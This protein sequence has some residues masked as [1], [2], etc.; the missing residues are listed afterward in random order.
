MSRFAL[1]LNQ[2]NSFNTL[3]PVPTAAIF[4]GATR[5]KGST[6]RKFNFCKAHSPTPSLCIN[7]FINIQGSNLAPPVPPV[8]PVTSSWSTV[9]GAGFAQQ[10]PPYP[11]LP[12]YS[13]VVDNSGNIYVSNINQISIYSKASQQWQVGTQISSTSGTTT[14]YLFYNNGVIYIGGNFTLLTSSNGLYLPSNYFASY[15]TTNTF[16]TDLNQYNDI[17]TPITAFTVKNNIIYIATQYVP[18]KGGPLLKTYNISTGLF[19]NILSSM[20]PLSI[21]DVINNIAVDGSNNIFISGIFDDFDNNVN[22]VLTIN[23]GEDQ[24]ETVAGYFNDII[25]TLTIDTNNNLYIGGKF[26]SYNRGFGR[27]ISMNYVSRLNSINTTS[28]FPL[29]SS[30]GDLLGEVNSIIIDSKN[31]FYIGGGF[32]TTTM[33]NTL[34]F[35]ATWSPSNPAFTALNYGLTDSVSSLF[36][37][38]NNLYLLG[39]FNGFYNSIPPPSPPPV[40]TCQYMA[41]RTNI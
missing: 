11:A 10:L 4:M 31:N 37:G 30:N 6:T 22:R 29:P 35:I 16:W 39:T 26:T 27:D 3:K 34:N 33:N 23:S 2:K 20:N 24:I 17:K 14:A 5:G 13:G 41:T 18:G 21:N 25:N 8:P 19:G 7:Q 12:L 38:N 36:I 40:T 9:P 15:N 1:G 32:T 28:W